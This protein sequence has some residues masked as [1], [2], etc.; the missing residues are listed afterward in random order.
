MWLESDI[1]TFLYNLCAN[2]FAQGNKA[3]VF[4][5]YFNKVY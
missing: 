5:V 2:S 1:F 3:F 4:I